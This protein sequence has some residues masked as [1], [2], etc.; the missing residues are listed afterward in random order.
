MGNIR[1]SC[2]YEQKQKFKN[3]AKKMEANFKDWA[4]ENKGMVNYQSGVD[5]QSLVLWWR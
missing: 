3:D 2:E 5:V 4:Q 1:Q